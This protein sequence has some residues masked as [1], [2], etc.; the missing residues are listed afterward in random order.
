[1]NRTYVVTGASSGIGQKTY[2]ILKAQGNTVIGVDLWKTD[3]NVDLSTP[4]GRAALVSQVTEKTGGKIDG[5]VASAGLA[6]PE[7]ITVAVNFFG[8][9]ATLEGLRPLLA[10]GSKPRAVVMSSIAALQKSD[11]AL[12]DA[13]MVGDE[14]TALLLAAKVPDLVYSSTKVAVTRWARRHAITPAWAGA[15]ILLN[16]VAPAIIQSPMTQS[17]ID[18][19]KMM[20]MMNQMMPT[21]VGRIGQPEDVANLL[22]FLVS[23][24]NSHMVGQM[25]YIDGGGEAV[26][27]GELVW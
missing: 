22:A 2:E 1:M 10:K 5:L 12:I 21:P 25:I 8:A 15:G 20:E 13:M 7:P 23:A 4:D 24:E 26:N 27:R 19:P 11:P 17:L 14:K 16:L 3:I 9:I 18:D 6:K